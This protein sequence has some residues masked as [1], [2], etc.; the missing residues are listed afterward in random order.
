MQIGAASTVAAMATGS[1]LTAGKR[2]PEA[3]T[4][5]IEHSHT[6]IEFV[7]RHLVV[8]KVRGRFK[9]FSGVIEVAED[10][11]ESEVTVSIDAASIDTGTHDRDRHLRSAQFLDV[12]RYPEITFES[13]SIE[14]VE[15]GWQITGELT[16]R[17]ISA[18]V[19]LD[20]VFHGVVV[21]PYAQAKSL[22]SARGIIDRAVYGLTW[23]MPLET[24]GLMLG[25]DVKIEIEA[26]LIPK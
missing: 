18:P 11:L 13:T 17:D 1:R 24:G 4:W 9:E 3:G 25:N 14:S 26:Q 7:A 6:Y 21:D 5:L 2:V 8:A 20:A 10:P 12:D 23:N 15:G 16:I 19:T 22:F